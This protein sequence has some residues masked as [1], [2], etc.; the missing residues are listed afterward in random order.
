M[1]VGVNGVPY[2]CSD[3]TK[4]NTGNIE[5]CYDWWHKNTI[6]IEVYYDKLR[7]EHLKSTPSYIV[8]VILH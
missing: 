2:D 6:R 7:Y 3:T 5:Q 4:W 1:Q 8:S